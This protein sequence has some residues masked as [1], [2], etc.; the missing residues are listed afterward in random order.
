MSALLRF[1]LPAFLVAGCLNGD[2]NTQ[3]AAAPVPDMATQHIFDLA[4]LDLYGAYNCSALNACERACM[5]KACVFM[6]RNMSTPTAVALENDLQS[7]FVQYCPTAMGMVCAPDA[8]GML[9]M[10]CNTCINNTYLPESASCSP[11]QNPDECHKCVAQANACT[12]DM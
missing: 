8:T 3:D 5:T 2:F 9:S 7:C 10:A 11:S 6:C 4:G 1:V 12:A